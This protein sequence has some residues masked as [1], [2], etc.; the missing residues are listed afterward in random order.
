VTHLGAGE[1]EVITLAIQEPGALVV[2]DDARA[3]KQARALGIRLTGTL[4]VL[5]KAKQLG[6]L[7]A[8]RPV[9]ER[10]EALRFY[11]DP[12]TRLAVL[13]LAGETGAGK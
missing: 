1:R 12:A 6:F 2:L 3:R 13:G 11:L 10:L 5:L 7:P 9:L 4:G 8:V